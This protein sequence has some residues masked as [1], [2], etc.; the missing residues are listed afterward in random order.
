[1]EF[2]GAFVTYGL[3]FIVLGAVA[4]GAILLGICLR[5]RK[6][7]SS[8]EEEQDCIIFGYKGCHGN[9]GSFCCKLF[10]KRKEGVKYVTEIKETIYR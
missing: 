6:N 3:K 1:M 5:K 9:D 4:F 7:A 2:L 8:V 10:G